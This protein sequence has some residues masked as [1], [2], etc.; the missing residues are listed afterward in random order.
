MHSNLH[1]VNFNVLC[2]VK[3]EKKDFLRE[4]AVRLTF[5]K[6]SNHLFLRSFSKQIL[7]IQ[8]PPHIRQLLS[9]DYYEE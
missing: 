2:I 9:M 7:S 6:A 1:G 8:I 4:R 5:Q 3:P